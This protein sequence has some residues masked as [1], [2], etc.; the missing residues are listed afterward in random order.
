MAARKL[1]VTRFALSLLAVGA[2]VL[3]SIASV[4][5]QTSGNGPV[6]LRVKSNAAAIT[7]GDSI[8]LEI[9]LLDVKNRAVKVTR[10]T[11]IE[12]SMRAAGSEA[13][14][15]EVIV[16][17]GE[18]VGRLSA[19]MDQAGVME[20]WAKHRNLLDGNT[21]INVRSAKAGT[22][23]PK[24]AREEAK[25]SGGA[26]SPRSASSSA[27]ARVTLRYSP[28]RTL[29]ADG[30]DQ[31]SIQAFLLDA[32]EVQANNIQLRLFNSAG[33]LIPIPLAISVAEGFGQASLTSNQIGTV[34][35]EYVSASPAIEIEGDRKLNIAFGP[36]ISRLV[37]D[38]SP[39]SITL[40]DAA[41]VNVKLLD[42]DD[43]PVATDTP[44]QVGFEI[45]AGRGTLEATEITIQPGSFKGRTAF[46]PTWRGEVRLSA[47]TPNLQPAEA[48]LRVTLP[49]TL[50]L[51]SAVG[52]LAGGFIAFWREQ[53]SSKLR[54]VIGLAT[55]FVFYWAFV[56]GVLPLLPREYILNP[57]SSLALSILGGWLGTEAFSIV[58]RR[59]GIIS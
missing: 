7:A 9:S 53:S 6:K 4:I 20:V 35:I 41:E 59:L 38:A 58:L 23:P 12:V 42:A 50:L 1:R 3:F 21:F 33:S 31:A 40:V 47:S 44:R 52:G 29:L 32:G 25:S 8:Q 55:G 5:S 18:E 39:P 13:L 43:K 10:D 46:T 15:R 30:V 19:K 14:R 28:Q 26:M 27:A 36:P 37:I 57:L 34:E 11:R 48:A 2:I 54:I 17:A 16:K 24:P 22:P 45:D 49:V 51:L 56:F